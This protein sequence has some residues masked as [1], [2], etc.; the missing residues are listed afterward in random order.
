MILIQ[1]IQ[2]ILKAD[3]NKTPRL[4]VVLLNTL[5]ADPSALVVTLQCGKQCNAV[6]VIDCIACQRAMQSMQR[7]PPS[8]GN[9]INVGIPLIARIDDIDGWGVG[10][11]GA[12]ESGSGRS[13]RTPAS[14][15]WQLIRPF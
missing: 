6:N 5:L 11:H 9:A 8:T 13:A 7:R 12:W 14:E 4:W 1:M 2:S 15:I 3:S 10:G